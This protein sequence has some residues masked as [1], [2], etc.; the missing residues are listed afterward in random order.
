LFALIPFKSVV[1]L[2]AMEGLVVPAPLVTSDVLLILQC[3]DT[4]YSVIGILREKRADCDY[5]NLKIPMVNYD[6]MNT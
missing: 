1:N 6:T 4:S 5:E 2:G 3:N